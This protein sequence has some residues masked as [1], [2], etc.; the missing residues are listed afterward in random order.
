MPLSGAQSARARALQDGPETS[1]SIEL[2]D[3]SRDYRYY[4]NKGWFESEYWYPA[5]IGPLK[6]SVGRLVDVISAR[7]CE[8]KAVSRRSIQN[9]RVE[10]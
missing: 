6:K 1:I 9:T 5:R 7:K 2:D 3:S 8:T 10:G 4:A